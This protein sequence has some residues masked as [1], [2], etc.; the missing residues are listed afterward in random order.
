MHACV[1]TSPMLS[2]VLQLY[3]AGDTDTDPGVKGKLL[4][5]ATASGVKVAKKEDV[6]PIHF[7]SPVALKAGHWYTLALKGSGRKETPSGKGG[8]TKMTG[9]M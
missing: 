4:Q 7:K 8:Q 6:F 3:D 5:E 2:M 1:T 9:V